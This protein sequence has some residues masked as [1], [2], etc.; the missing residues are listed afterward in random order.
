MPESRNRSSLRLP[1]LALM[2]VSLASCASAPPVATRYE[3]APMGEAL[4]A[5]PSAE[6]M[7]AAAPATTSSHRGLE[8]PEA[9]IASEQEHETFAA[10]RT[11]AERAQ[12]IERF[13]ARRD[14]TPGDG[15]NEARQEFERRVAVAESAFGQPGSPGW[16]TSFG[17]T[18]LVVGFPYSVTL[19]RG[20]FEETRSASMATPVDARADDRVIWRYAPA[21]LLPEYEPLPIAYD[22]TFYYLSGQWR[23][24]CEPI[25]WTGRRVVGGTIVGLAPTTPRSS[26]GSSS[27]SSTDDMGAG[28]L[29][30]APPSGGISD[31]SAPHIYR[32]WTDLMVP[33]LGRSGGGCDGIWL[34]ALHA[35]GGAY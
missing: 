33:A 10:L 8:G 15:V 7:G 20:D 26:Y 3:W 24:G 6:A 4:A 31:G 14:A 9:I 32:W 29:G 27:A 28:S 34:D 5:A 11:D 35:W 23:L 22:L 12:F 21:D 30:V 18:L 2:V 16:K 1:A 17:L 25:A 13:W 19:A